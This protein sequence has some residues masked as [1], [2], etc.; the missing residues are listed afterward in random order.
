MRQADDRP[1][2]EPRVDARLLRTR[3]LVDLRLDAPGCTI[4][5][6]DGGAELVAGPDASLVV[7]FPPQHLGEEDWQAGAPPPPRRSRPRPSS[8]VA[9]G[10]TRLVYELPEGTRIA[11]HARGGARGAPGSAARVA[12]N[13][14]PAGEAASTAGIEPPADLETAIEAPYHLVVSPSARG[15]FRHRSTPIGPPDR[16]ELWR[17]HLTVRADDGTFDDERR[18]P[19]H[20]PRPLEPRQRASPPPR[21]STSR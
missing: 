5:P 14:T 15:A 17:T 18:R 19:A 7:H 6:T 16:P 20:R 4:E 9:A 10:P 12:P 2:E 8:H 21:A 11:L 3:D 13:A 1:P